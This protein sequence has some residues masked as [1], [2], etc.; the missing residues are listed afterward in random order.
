MILFT[1]ELDSKMKAITRRKILISLFCTLLY[2][3]PHSM[4]GQNARFGIVAGPNFSTLSSNFFEGHFRVGFHAGVFGQFKF[5]EKWALRPELFYSQQGMT[6]RDEPGSYTKFMNYNNYINLPVQLE[7]FFNDRFSLQFGPGLGF[8]LKAKEII[9]Y[10]GNDNTEDVT[11]TYNRVD[12]G[13]YLGFEYSFK[14]HF[15]LGLRFYSSFMYVEIG[16]DRKRNLFF[17]L[18][19]TYKF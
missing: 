8:L 4:H 13:F 12:V 10:P 2:L 1:I 17:Q 11:D 3:V 15:G 14:K 6:I 18:P 19:L 5:S 7:Y 16:A 9:K